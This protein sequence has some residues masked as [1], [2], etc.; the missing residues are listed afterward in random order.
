[1]QIKTLGPWTGVFPV[2][3]AASTSIIDDNI[4][5]REAFMALAPLKN[6]GSQNGYLK[7]L[8]QLVSIAISLTLFTPQ[9]YAQIV[10]TVKGASVI[11]DDYSGATGEQFYLLDQN[12]KRRAIIEISRVKGTRALGK[13]LKG[14]AAV[15]FTLTPRTG[16]S[17]RSRSRGTKGN[18]RIGGLLGYSLDSQ[19]VPRTGASTLDMNGSGLSF[20]G[21]YDYNG[22]IPDVGVRFL[23]GIEQFKVYSGSF[24][25]EI[26]YLTLDALG[27]YF[28]SQDSFAFWLGGGLGLAIPMSKSSDA[29]DSESIATATLLYLALGADIEV[30]KEFSIPVQ[31]DYAF[32]LPATDVKTS[33]LGI[34]AGVSFKF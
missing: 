32:F 15:G 28:I 16:T 27:R 2:C 29:L 23:G 8:L 1:M 20:K 6:T 33:A 5:P 18:S 25:T 26:T 12:N 14:R 30:N 4:Y 17:A 24:E 21:L 10:K 22:I 19:T 31:L 34:R 7:W 9:S 13:V 11:V 3:I